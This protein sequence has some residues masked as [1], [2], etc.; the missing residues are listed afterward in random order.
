MLAT[1]ALNLSELAALPDLDRLLEL[2]KRIQEI[3]VM[4][5][6]VLALV[7]SFVFLLAWVLSHLRRPSTTASHP[8]ISTA[9]MLVA[10]LP[11]GLT[12]VAALG[13][14]VPTLA[15]LTLKSFAMAVVVAAFAWCL[16]VAAIVVG[17][18]KTNLAR[19]RRALL[20]A[21]TPWYCLALY[22]STFL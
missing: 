3:L 8:V 6:V 17:G 9:S 10:Y 18:S 5:G 22:L 2:L 4:G 1:V 16:A 20:L 15:P 7:C 12:L 14:L 13:W 21:G 11:V 19:A